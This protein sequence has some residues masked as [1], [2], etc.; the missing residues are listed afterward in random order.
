MVVLPHNRV[1]IL[2]QENAALLSNEHFVA[3]DDLTNGLT[4]IPA[5]YDQAFGP[6]PE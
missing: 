3:V 2:T 1:F 6:A 4:I 5:V